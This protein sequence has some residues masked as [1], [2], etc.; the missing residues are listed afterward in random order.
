M[1]KYYKKGG[2]RVDF[3]G[4]DIMIDTKNRMF[5]QF[6]EDTTFP[7]NGVIP[8][9]QKTVLENVNGVIQIKGEN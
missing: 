8:K 6:K 2:K 3:H 9:G 4:A 5:V 1:A 7:N